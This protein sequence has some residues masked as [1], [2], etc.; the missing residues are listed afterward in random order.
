[1]NRRTLKN[2]ICHVFCLLYVV[3]VGLPS[4]QYQSLYIYDYVDRTLLWAV[5]AG[6]GVPPRMPAII[7]LFRDGMRAGV[8]LDDAEC[9]VM[10]DVENGLR[11]GCVLVPLLLNT[12]LTVVLRVAEKRFTADDAVVVDS[13]VQLQRK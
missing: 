10:F 9:S 12:L 8:R 2:E 13:M 3:R 1:M 6:F 7:R 5:L 11:Q 4:I